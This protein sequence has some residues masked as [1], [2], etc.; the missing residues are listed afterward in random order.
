MVTTREFMNRAAPAT[1]DDSALLDAYSKTIAAVV[2]RV[3]SSV[4]NIRVVSERGPGGGS[5]FSIA[6]D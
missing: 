4:V 1:R 6:R 2:N 3:A 5:V